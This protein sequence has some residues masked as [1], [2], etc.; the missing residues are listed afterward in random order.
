MYCLYNLSSFFL[1]RMIPVLFGE[2]S[3]FPQ[4]GS[5]MKKPFTQHLEIECFAA[6]F[7]FTLSSLLS[8]CFKFPHHCL[9]FY[10][11]HFFS[12]FSLFFIYSMNNLSFSP[13]SASSFFI[14]PPPLLCYSNCMSLMPHN[15][16]IAS[17][18]IVHVPAQ[19][20]KLSWFPW[21]PERS[22]KTLTQTHT[23]SHSQTHTQSSFTIWN[24]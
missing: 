14:A 24:C 22:E 19:W 16:K 11:L 23:H 6:L 10:S 12:H 2:S 8:L 21:G 5:E 13:L 1:H 17:C 7:Q 9:L 3:F 20:M 4:A 18:D 15:N